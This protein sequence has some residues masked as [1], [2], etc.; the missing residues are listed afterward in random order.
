VDHREQE[1]LLPTITEF[2]A[3]MLT[4]LGIV[5]VQDG[6]DDF[7]AF[8]FRLKNRTEQRKKINKYKNKCKDEKKKKFG[9]RNRNPRVTA[10]LT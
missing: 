5:F 1:G 6:T 8:N 4:Y 9:R 3:N 10:P 7:S 2:L